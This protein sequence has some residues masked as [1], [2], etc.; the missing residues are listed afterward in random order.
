[1]I[2]SS[3][4]AVLIIGI[5]LAGPISTVPA[6]DPEELI[7]MKKAGISEETIRLYLELELERELSPC[8]PS[9]GV[10]EVK[11]AKGRGK[12]IRYFYQGEPQEG[13]SRQSGGWKFK[14]EMD[15]T[16]YIIIENQSK[17]GG[18]GR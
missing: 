3:F 8:R 12:V 5:L 17:P 16:P 7:R 15:L 2:R 1:M 9:M 18:E 10:E 13:P 11:D 6:V 4:C 14:R